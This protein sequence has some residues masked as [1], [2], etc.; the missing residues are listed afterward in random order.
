MNH[1]PKSSQDDEDDEN[2]NPFANLFGRLSTT[3]VE[4]KAKVN[5]GNGEGDSGADDLANKRA[6]RARNSERPAQVPRA[7]SPDEGHE[8]MPPPPSV[9]PPSVAKADKK[10]KEKG[11]RAKKS[12][13]ESVE[14]RKRPRPGPELPD[15]DEGD[16]AITA[17]DAELLQKFQLLTNDF[18]DMDPA[19]AKDEGSFRQWLKDSQS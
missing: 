2:F 11:K 17:E 14:E 9:P 7:K 3:K 12:V 13:D 8:D 19:S 6:N 10:P 15:G 1:A 4:D 18:D 16:A 5:H